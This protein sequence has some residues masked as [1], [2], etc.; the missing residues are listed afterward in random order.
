MD[1]DSKEIGIITDRVPEATCSKCGCKIDV[2]GLEPFVGVECPDCG[3]IENVPAKLGQFLLL[4]LIGKGGMGGVY[5]AED[6]AL[7]RHVAI[8]VML[9]S[10]GD[11]QEFVETFKREAQAVAKL[12]HPNIVQIYA[13]G[14]EKGQPYIVME[15]V[16]GQRL[17]KMMEGGQQVDQALVMKIAA[18]VGDH[19]LHSEG[20]VR[21]I[22]KMIVEDITAARREGNLVHIMELKVIL[23]RFMKLF[24][25]AA[26]APL[27]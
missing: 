18:D 20:G 5:Y 10:L 6:T 2:E 7:G 21:E 3:A 4:N 24:T 1:A 15:L 14:K 12:N 26:H 27:G 8:K 9:Q 17:D 23:A 22:C 13:F 19:F 16:G 11:N 25:R